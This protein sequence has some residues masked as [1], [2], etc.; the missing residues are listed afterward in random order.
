MARKRKPV[1]EEHRRE[2]LGR[3]HADRR[4]ANRQVRQLIEGVLHRPRPFHHAARLAVEPHLLPWQS[5]ITRASVTRH[6]NISS[7][8]QM[9]RALPG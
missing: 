1:E 5:P 6:D 2:A 3:Q 7:H 8:I 9:L 4:D